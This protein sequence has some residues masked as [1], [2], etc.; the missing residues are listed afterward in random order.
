MRR[1]GFLLTAAVLVVGAANLSAQTPN[2][3]GTWTLI[4]DSNAPAM[5]ESG[6]A[7]PPPITIEQDSKTLTLTLPSRRGDIKTVFNLDDTDSKLTMTNAAGSE[8][9]VTLH[10]RWSG[11]TLVATETR[12]SNTATLKL[13]LDASGNLTFA[14]TQPAQ[15]G[16]IR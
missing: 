2:F 7:A 8:I 4:A 13:S 15:D 11:S 5:G 1:T 3:A 9:E 16:A 6:G 14:V 10:A 12:G